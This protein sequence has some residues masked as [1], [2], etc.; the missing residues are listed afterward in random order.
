M[1]NG[2]PGAD[3]RAAGDNGFLELPR[4]GVLPPDDPDVLRSL[5]V[6]AP[7]LS[8]TTSAG[9]GVYRYGTAAAGTEDGYG[10]CNVGDS[11]DCTV[12]GKPWAGT[13]DAQGQNK[14]SGHLWP[15]LAG[16]K[17]ENLLARGNEAGA[18]RLWVA[19]ADTAAGVGLIPEQAWENADLPPSPYGT[20]PECASIGFRNG[21]ATGS[22]SPLTWSQ[23]QFVRLTADLRAGGVAET[24]TDT[25]RRYLQQAPPAAVTVTVTAP[26]DAQVRGSTLVEGST[27]PG[28]T[29]DVSAVN[30]DADGDALLT[31]TTAAAD[32][33]Y[34]VTAQ[35]P[36][37]TTR[38]TVAATSPAGGTGT[39]AVTVVDDTVAGALL[40]NVAD[41]DGDDDGPGTYAYPTAGDFHDGAYDLQQFQVYDSG[42]DTVT[43]RVRTRDL[44]PTF[45]SAPGARRD[46]R[47]GLDL[48]AGAGR[49]ER[50]QPGRGPRL[51]RDP[52]ALHVR[53]VRAGRDREPD[54]RGGPRHG[55]R[56]D[57]RADAARG[58]P[59]GRAGPTK[60]PVVVAAI[61]LE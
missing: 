40:L 11:T 23:A 17:A 53:R 37:G 54:L 25:T 35:V 59:G 1:G 50:V 28:S 57:G 58:R 38:L 14:G 34:A 44:T 4:L 18:A 9:T 33:S 15:V 20:P 26:A 61:R 41:P 51:H 24:P 7:V 55:G 52:T 60:A 30:L 19:M 13:C 5:Q 31:S 45:G 12:Q 46:P 56:G 32:G 48:R 8:R 2:G 16:E 27:V 21:R 36:P 49:S 47:T 6:T 42:P 10:D 43:F 29:V 22:A 3:Q 39:A